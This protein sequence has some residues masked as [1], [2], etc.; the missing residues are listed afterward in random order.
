M[1]AQMTLTGEVTN[2][3]SPKGFWTARV[4]RWLSTA[5]LIFDGVM[6]LIKPPVVVQSTL[7]LGY[8]ESAI[9]GIGVALLVCTALY[10]I[11]RTSILGAVLLTGYLGGAVASGVRVQAPLFNIVFPILF[12]CLVWGGL[13]LRDARLQEL[14]PLKR[15]A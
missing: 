14:L 15:N 1:T 7:Q 11:P 10:L 2:E 9:V 13:W 6:K 3:I 8:P 5:F 4:L 12:A